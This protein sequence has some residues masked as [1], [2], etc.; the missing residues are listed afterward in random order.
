MPGA[1]SL[2]DT[3]PLVALL[4]KQDSAHLQCSQ[5]LG[6]FRG[7]LFTTEPVL[8]EAMYLLRTHPD[9]QLACLDFFLR[10]AAVAIPMTLPRLRRCRVLVETYRSVPMDFADASLVALAEEL[11][12]GRVF[13]LDR[14]GFS[15]Y[16]WRRKRPFSIQP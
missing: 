8:T 11:D 5:A 15:A 12:I 3:S 2:L 4:S 6:A 13:T 16:R 7:R 10:G 9:G 1:D 14:R